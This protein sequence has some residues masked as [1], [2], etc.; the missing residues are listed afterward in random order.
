M[1]ALPMDVQI[2]C[3]AEECAGGMVQL[4]NDAA[5]KVAQTE[6]YREGCA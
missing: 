1:N 4:A 6:Q 3:T 5:T 2:K